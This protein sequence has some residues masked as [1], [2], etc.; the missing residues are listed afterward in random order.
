MA[1]KGAQHRKKLKRVVSSPVDFD[2]AIAEVDKVQDLTLIEI[3]AEPL[4]TIVPEVG[5]SEIVPVADQAKNGSSSPKAES[6]PSVELEERSPLTEKSDT[7][8]RT[9]GSDET[10]NSSNPRTRCLSFTR[11]SQKMPVFSEKISDFR[12]QLLSNHLNSVESSSVSSRS[13]SSTSNESTN[14]SGHKSNNLKLKD[15]AAIRHRGRSKC[16]IFSGSSHLSSGSKRRNNGSANRFH[17]QG[18][19]S[20][21][22]RSNKKPTS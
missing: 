9:F 6:I 22:R 21:P 12:Q 16:R 7:K 2:Q 1:N 5:V 4:E 20:I 19:R 10:Q 15:Y 13:D 3:D 14:I 11:L 17:Q 8:K 18:K